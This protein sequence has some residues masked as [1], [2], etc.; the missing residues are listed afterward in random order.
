MRNKFIKYV[1]PSMITFLVTGIYISIDGF[2]VGRVVGDI[3]IASINMAWPLA[4]VI[5]ALGTSIGMGGA[6]HMSALN[7]AGKKKEAQKILGNTLVYLAIAAVFIAAFLLLFGK[8]MLTLLGASGELLALSDNYLKILAY[9]AAIQIFSVGITPLLRNQN[10]AWIAMVLMVS[11]SII[12]TALSGIFVLGF[13]WGVEGAAVATLI[14]QSIALVP[15]VIILAKT[16]KNLFLVIFSKLSGSFCILRSAL[17]VF[18]LSFIPAVTI[19]ILNRQIVTYGG[20]KGLAVFAIASYVISV[21][22]LL[23]QGIGEGS[24][25]LI[26]YYYDA[27]KQAKVKQLK[28]WTYYTGIAVGTL[29]FI[30]IILSKNYIPHFF[31]AS[32]ETSAALQKAL[33]LLAASLPLY[34][35]SRAT[36]EFFNAIKK[37]HFSSIMVY[38]E[39]LV[40]LPICAIVLPIFMGLT[41]VWL[42]VFIVQALISLVG[43]FLLKS[44][45]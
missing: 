17:P 6:I 22:Q 19:I 12:D 32:A 36:T 15:A 20:A 10:K 40:L 7:G 13:K 14:G 18:G 26:S 1:V 2:F 43:I 4:A 5:L 27:N 34:S 3:G 41:G 24:Q 44:N 30:I 8:T 23:A 31:G 16:E 11:N 42:T 29:V 28:R 35:F 37:S 9:G 25:P 45:K 38:G 39:A 33:P 21:G